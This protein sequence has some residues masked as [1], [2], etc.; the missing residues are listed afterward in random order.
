MGTLIQVKG[1]WDL[2]KSCK[3]QK[4][5]KRLFTNTVSKTREKTVYASWDRGKRMQRFLS[6]A[7][8]HLPTWPKL[9]LGEWLFCYGFGKV[10]IFFKMGFL[11]LSLFNLILIEFEEIMTARRMTLVQK[12]TKR[13]LTLRKDIRN[14]EWELK[15]SVAI[16]PKNEYLYTFL[17]F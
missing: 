3:E 12:A 15:V 1:D 14:R 8:E 11:L 16:T 9:W 13:E 2:K 10:F 7:N 6:R 5:W 4:R 17:K